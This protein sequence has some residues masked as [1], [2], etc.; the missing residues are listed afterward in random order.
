MT[1]FP[2]QH[3]ASHVNTPIVTLVTVALL[4]VAAAVQSATS[5]DLGLPEGARIIPAIVFLVLSGAA[6]EHA[7]GHGAFLLGLLLCAL[8]AMGLEMAAGSAGSDGFG[9]LPLSVGAMT[10]GLAGMFISWQIR[11]LYFMPGVFGRVSI[12]SYLLMVLWLVVECSQVIMSGA[13]Y[14]QLLLAVQAVGGGFVIGVVTN[15]LSHADPAHLGGDYVERVVAEGLADADQLIKDYQ[16]PKARRVLARLSQLAPQNVE[17]QRANYAAWKFDPTHNEFHQA[18]AV[19]LDRPS[20]D[21]ASNQLVIE[22]Y[23]D[24]LAVTQGQ[25]QLPLGL[26]L[27]LARLFVRNGRMKQAANIVNV[28]LQQRQEHKDMA[29][30]ILSIAEGYVLEDRA[31]KAVHYADTVIALYPGSRAALSA[32]SMLKGLEGKL[33]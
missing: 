27:S 1:V 23:A 28:H 25:P 33:T 3:V 5:F 20:T 22:A 29:E 17:V 21:P 6:V 18:A 11:P 14:G 4:A 12:P 13:G 15:R 16:L 32:Q 24:Y 30:S 19:L 7:V 31:S 9:W 10:S 2:D 8:L 26:D